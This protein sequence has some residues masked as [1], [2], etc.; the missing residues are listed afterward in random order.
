[1]CGD[2]SI[3]RPIKTGNID[4]RTLEAIRAAYLNVLSE[5]V[6]NDACRNGEPHD[7][8]ISNG[9][10][11]TLILASGNATRSTPDDWGCWTKSANALFELLDHTFAAEDYG[12]RPVIK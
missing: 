5:G 4:A 8:I 1:M 11:P 7:I 10:V 6:K 3:E 9:G 12:E 2:R